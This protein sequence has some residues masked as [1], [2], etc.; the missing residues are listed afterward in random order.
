MTEETKVLIYSATA[1]TA[2]VGLFLLILWHE[3]KS[4]LRKERQRKHGTRD[5]RSYYR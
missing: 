3:F 2:G 1:G 5:H 4:K